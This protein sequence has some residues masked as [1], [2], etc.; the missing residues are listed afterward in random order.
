MESNPKAE[1]PALFRYGLI[2]A[3]LLEAF[4][5][6]AGLMESPGCLRVPC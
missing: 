3:L 4:A 2:A 5:D 1:K 6:L